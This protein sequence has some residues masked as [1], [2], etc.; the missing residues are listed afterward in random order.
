MFDLTP[1]PLNKSGKSRGCYHHRSTNPM[2]QSQWCNKS[3]HV[4]C[5]KSRFEG[6]INM[7]Q[8]SIKILWAEQAENTTKANDNRKA[9]LANRHTC[10][11]SV[12]SC[13]CRCIFKL[14][15]PNN[16]QSTCQKREIGNLQRKHSNS[17]PE[18]L[19]S[20]EK[21][22]GFSSGPLPCSHYTLTLQWLTQK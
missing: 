10:C 16:L 7:I 9:M 5:T 12:R 17:L 15:L 20:R 14:H 8:V 18:R 11:L 6:V 19:K 13:V 21:A 1:S 2:A 3:S 22:C 4:S